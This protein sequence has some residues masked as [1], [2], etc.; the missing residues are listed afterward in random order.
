[1]PTLLF[2]SAD[3]ELCYGK[4]TYIKKVSKLLFHKSSVAMQIF[5]HGCF[6]LCLK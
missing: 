4:N 3:Y 1:M 6:A 2:S 5:G